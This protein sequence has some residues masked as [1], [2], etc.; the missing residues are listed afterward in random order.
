MDV[1]ELRSFNKFCMIPGSMSMHM[2]F[3]SMKS[4]KNCNNTLRDIGKRSIVTQHLQAKNY[5]SE[6]F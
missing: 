6:K 4:I 5:L 3:V 1:Y 2:Y